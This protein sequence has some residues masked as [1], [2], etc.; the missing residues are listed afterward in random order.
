MSKFLSPA[1]AKAAI[2]DTGTK[3]ATVTFQKVDGTLREISGL[4]RPTS[5]MVGGEGGQM[6]SARLKKN[7]LIAIWSPQIARE[8]GNPLRGWRSV[9]DGAII[10]I[11]TEGRTY[12]AG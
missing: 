6:A 10:A 2:A 3:F 4:F 1:V 8:A 12:T 5:K 7:G 9:R 11:K